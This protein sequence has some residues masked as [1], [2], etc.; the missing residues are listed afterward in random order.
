MMSCYLRELFFVKQCLS[1]EILQTTKHYCAIINFMTTA[2]VGLMAEI[3]RIN[4]AKLSCV[5]MF[6][7]NELDERSVVHVGQ[8]CLK[9]SDIWNDS[10]AYVEEAMEG[11]KKMHLLKAPAVIWNCT[12]HSLRKLYWYSSGHYT[13]RHGLV[14][15]SFF[16][17]DR[18]WLFHQRGY[19]IGRNN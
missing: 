5:L 12:V 4:S 14:T 7:M 18:H 19:L 16:F 15:L 17:P 9:Q 2:N 1:L 6:W 8:R 11:L 13:S 3:C 10:Q